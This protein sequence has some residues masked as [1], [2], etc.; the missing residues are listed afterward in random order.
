MAER[1]AAADQV[2]AAADEVRHHNILYTSSRV[3][4][5]DAT[6]NNEK[7][8]HGCVEQTIVRATERTLGVYP[9]AANT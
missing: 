6:P 1:G 7:P 3:E 4:Q 2:R 5:R 8:S 9:R